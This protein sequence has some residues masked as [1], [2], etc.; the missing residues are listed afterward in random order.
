MTTIL[1][2]EDT[3]D[4]REMMVTSLKMRNYTVITAHNGSDGVYAAEE[5]HPDLII[6]DI[7]MP[8]L[9]GYEVFKRL[10]DVEI[11][12]ETPFI[13]ATA[14]DQA[15]DIER[16]RIMGADDYIV[17]PFGVEDFLNTVQKVLE[18]RDL[19]Q[20]I[21]DSDF[22]PE[23]YVF[24]S[25]SHADRSFMKALRNH[26]QEAGFTL[27]TDEQIEPG[28]E[29]ELVLARMITKSSCVLCMLS[30]NAAQSKWVGREIAYAEH[31]GTRVLPVLMH[32]RQRDSI[33]IRLI[34]HQFIDLRQDFD[35]GFTRLC[36]T[37]TSV[38]TDAS[39]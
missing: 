22:E 28:D 23:Q 29:W 31:A 1:V 25:Y 4:I 21:D 36:N 39:E 12:P 24:I 32:G 38:M 35:T 17:K 16:A 14:L 37:L 34:N 33:P 3:K 15:G 9:N 19:V 8:L 6:C 30:E 10:H 5:H 20:S 2:I 13:F 11:V 18:R 7:M 27:W 26:L